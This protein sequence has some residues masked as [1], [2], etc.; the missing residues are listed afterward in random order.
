M[1]NILFL[2]SLVFCIS[3]AK[4]EENSKDVDSRI[5]QV[6]P[7]TY[8]CVMHPEIHATKP[9]KCPK[10]GMVLVKEKLQKAAKQAAKPVKASKGNIPAQKPVPAKS[11]SLKKEGPQKSLPKETASVSKSKPGKTVR[12]DLYVRDTIVNFTGK[13][14]R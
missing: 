7:F 11:E 6:Q 12:Y 1:K 14:K 2:I 5:C 8:T 9:G 13:A 4:G 3:V 10:C